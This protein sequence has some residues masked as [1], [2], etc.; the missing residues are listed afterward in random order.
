MCKL[1]NC[2]NCEKEHDGTYGSGRFC[3]PK[4]ARSFS[5][6]EK[7]SDINDKVSKKMSSDII[8]KKCEFSNCN[9]ILIQTIKNRKRFCNVI[10]SNNHNNSLP[11]KRKKSSETA[12]KN[13]FG[14]NRNKYAYGWY[15]SKYAG[16]VFLESSY[17]YKVALELDENNISW[18][19]PKYIKWFD[20]NINKDRKYYPD[21]YLVDYNIY[22]DPKND[23]LITQDEEKIKQVIIQNNII[24]I[25]LDKNNLTWNNIKK[26]ISLKRLSD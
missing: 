8:N 26:I 15:E 4:C 23:Y 12:I 1:E 21:F 5:T 7:R 2:E 11:E 3:S 18:I 24:I 9:N 19:R 16:K 14:G 6:K 10:C 20:L 17:E 25:I 22:L 13:N